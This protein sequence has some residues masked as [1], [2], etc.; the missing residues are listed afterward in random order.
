[1][2]AQ[3]DGKAETILLN[4]KIAIQD[5][6]RSFA[7]ALAMRGD[8]F[9]AVGSDGEA[10]GHKGADTTV[11][12][13]K[14]RTV[15]PGL[16]DSHMHMIRGGRMYN[17]EVRWDGVQSLE[18]GL[19]RIS[20]QAKRTPSPQW[21]RVVG[22][23]SEFQFKEKRMPTL[24]EINRLAPSTPV[25]VLHLYHL[26]LLNKKALS[27]AGYTKD[28]PNPPE[29]EI[30]KDE[31]GEPTG[32]L[33]SKPAA[34]I[35]YST[36]DK[37][38]KLS[39][40]DQL[41]STRQFMYELNRLG[42]TSMIDAGG[43][44]QYYPDDYAVIQG[45][46]R[47]GL[48]TVRTAYHLF[49]Q[50]PGHELED[51][52]NWSR[53]LVPGSG[54]PYLR[55]NGAGESLVFSAADWED[56]PEPRP[57]LPPSME[58]EL[59]KVVS[60]LAEKRWPFRLHATYGESIERFLDVFEAVNET[61]PFDGLRWCFDHAETISSKS[62]R[63]VKKMGGGIAIQDRMAFQGEY[64]AERY[65]YDAAKTAPPII[66]MME[67]G[68]PIGAGTDATRVASYNPWIA[69]YWLVSGRTVG[70]LELSQ[71]NRLDRVEA[72][73]LWTLGSAWFS[74]EQD[75]KGSIE[76]GKLAD[77]AVLSDDYFSVPEDDIR[78]IQS[79]LTVVGGKV[80][81]AAQEFSKLGPAPLKVSPGW[82]PNA[83]EH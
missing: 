15:I 71:R 29:A 38:P 83:G 80:V 40:D 4:G 78:N 10:L 61:T 56:F 68:I 9:V 8:R 79:L 13:L 7:S 16:N 66:D 41:N 72:L 77:V 69:L 75:Q 64:F 65:G 35:L 58:G 1:M 63:R 37:A 34:R 18:E 49:T 2:A 33:I 70:G 24:D 32:M 50:R 36:L 12:D 47:S 26:A 20:E 27:E 5:S 81:F 53:T 57:E 31:N 67:A 48:M 30:Q 43:G 3:S 39:H 60:V 42:I 51:Y 11:I 73:G 28:T 62:I 19:R 21:V 25:F 44:S 52:T 59:A 55:L 74:G 6:R 76:V 54:D 14:G 17:T 45:L 46:A 82:S 22:G 23:W